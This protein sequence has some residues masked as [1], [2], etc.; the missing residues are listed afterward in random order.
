MSKAGENKQCICD[1]KC[2]VES[3]IHNNHKNGCTA[4]AIEIGPHFATNSS[5]TVCNTFEEQSIS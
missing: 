1:V 2:D 5:D 4:Q 3:C